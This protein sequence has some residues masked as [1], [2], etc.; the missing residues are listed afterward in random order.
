MKISINGVLTDADTARIDPTDRGF[1]LGDGVFETIVV[2]KNAVRH[3]KAHLDRLRHGAGVLGIPLPGDDQH[4][5]GMIGAAITANALTEAVVRVTLTR[6]PG[7][8][9]LASPAKPTPTLVITAGPLPPP[10]E[11]AKVIIATVTRRNEHSP[12]SGI[13]H[14]NYL[15]NIL[16]RREAEATGADDAILLN[17]AGRVAESTV[18]NVFVLVDSFML[19][20]PLDD[21]ALPG[22]IRG[23]AIKLARAEEKSLSLEMLMRASE[24]FL[25]NA[26]GVRP[27]THINGKAVGDGEPGLITQLL[28]TRL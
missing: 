1:T 20:P 13:K 23:E 28:A 7:A 25:T 2:R 17:T 15:D 16:A 4:L 18:A 11:P 5:A 10:A 12:L 22:I 6:G 9:G 27:V 8:R 21:G 24:V 3:L 14:L 26:L 19:T